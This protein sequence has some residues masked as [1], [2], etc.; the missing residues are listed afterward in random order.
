MATGIQGIDNVTKG[1]EKA[2]IRYQAGASKGMIEAVAFIR[3]DM[4]NTPPLIPIGKSRPGYTGG[5][6]RSTWFVSFVKSLQAGRVVLFGFSANY[7][8]Y[9]HEMVEGEP[10]GEGGVVGIINW[11]RPNSGPKFLEA[12][13]KRNTREIMR[14]LQANTM[15][16]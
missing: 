5:H 1:L 2:L 16:A 12:A 7:A 14:I 9:V 4:D 13:L 8:L 15:K 11:S 6:L 3:E 10:W